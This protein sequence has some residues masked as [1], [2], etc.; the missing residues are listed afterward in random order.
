[1]KPGQAPPPLDENEEIAALIE[2]LHLTGQRLEE[3]TAGEVDGVADAEGRTF[4]LR[5]I[6]EQLRHIEA[7]KQAAI[8][9]A[10]PAHIALLD[11]QGGIVSVNEAW[12]QFASAN[13]LQGPE[14]AIGVNYLD[15]CGQ[16][17]GDAAADARLVAAGIRSVLSGEAKGFSLEYSCHSP[18][19]QRW[20]LMTATPLSDDH[21]NG[22]VVMHQDITEQKQAE[23]S[24]QGSKDLLQLVMENVPSRIFWKDRNLRYLG[25]NARFAKDAGHS[26]P[27]ELTGKTD[28]EMGWKD[29]AEL[30][31][32]D[33]RAVLE[34]GVPKLN[35]EEPQTT[36]DGNTIW[37]R[38]SKVPLRDRNNQTIGILGLYEDI[39]ERRQAEL[40]LIESERRFSDML[41]NVQLISIMLDREA[42]ITYCN[43][44]LL[45]LTGW[46]REEVIG[47]NWFDVYTPP[48]IDDLKGAFFSELLANLPDTW[49]H[50]NEI[51]TR[52]GEHRLIRWNNSVL[53]SAD[54]D[55]IG[56]ASIGEDISERKRAE[57]ALLQ[58][59]RQN[60][61]ILASVEEGIYGIDRDGGISFQNPAAAKLL[62]YG[63]DELIGRHAHATMHYARADGTPYPMAQCPIHATMID[64]VVRRVGNEVFWRKDGSS[65][66]VEYTT[67]PIHDEQNAIVGVV[68][69][70]RDITERKR[71]ELELRES[72]RMAGES[73]A[74]TAAV[75][76]IAAR[77]QAILDTVVDG[78]ITIDEDGMVET[79][80]P[81]A[82]R[83]FGYAADAVIGRN[84]KML[85]PGPYHSQHDAYL[86][87][88][89]ATG[90]AR[91]I[92]S[93]R[94]VMGRR[95]DGGS[96]PLDLSV[97]EMLLGGKRH[98]TG[99]V[100][101][102][103]E[104]KSAER[105]VLDARIEAERANAA[106]DI[107]LAN[108]SHEIRTPMNGVIGMIEVLQQSSLNGPQM[109]MANVIHDSAFAL[110]DV[111][112]DILDFSKIEAGKFEIDR[113]PMNVADVVE[114]ACE[115]L[116]SMALKKAVEL[117]LFTDPAIP[118]RVLG[119]PGR[120]RQ[121][122]INLANNA[123][124]FSSG[125]QRTGRVSVR[126]V[127][128]KINPERVLLEFQVVD[129]G[130][131]ID[132]ATLARLFTPFN[133]ADASTTRNY[134]G[135]G[136][137]LAI[138][139]QL[140]NLMDGDI[141]VQS[142]PG[143]GSLFSARIPF[144]LP[145][146]EDNADRPPHVEADSD[147]QR[148]AGLSCLVVGYP[149]GMA[150][151]LA[152]YLSYGEAIVERTQDLM[153]AQH[154]IAARPPG[155]PIVIIDTRV[156]S[157]PLEEL[158]ATA[159]AHP[160]S[161]THFVVIRRGLRRGL[162]EED[163]H[164]VSVDGNIL[165]RR[166]LLNAVAIA[167]GRATTPGQATPPDKANA[168]VASLPGETPLRRDGRILVAE[169]N[170]INR[171]VIQHQL[172]LLG[173]VADLADDGRKALARWHRG[174]YALLLTDLHMPNMDGLE[175]TAAIR[176][177]EGAGQHLP[178]VALTAN[179]LKSEAV[180]CLAAGMDDYLTKPVLLDRLQAMLEKW[181]PMPGRDTAAASQAPPASQ[182]LAV[183]D[184]TV[185]PKQIGN[186]PALI[187]RFFEDY[188]HSAQ[189]AAD[190]I[191]AA[192]ARGDWK[193]AGDGGH[194]LKS[195]SRAIGALAL[196]EVCARLEQAGKGGDAD[197][198]LA[199]EFEQ[200][201][202]AAFAAMHQADVAAP[203][204]L[205]VDD[206]AFQ[207]QLLSQQLAILGLDR[208]DA[209]TSGEQALARLEAQSAG[210]QLIFLDL[211]MPGM[212]GVEFIRRL[213]AR[214]YTGALI[215]VSG[216]DARI[217]ETA[218]RLA[219]AHRLN[220]LGHMNKPVQPERLEALLERWR[221][222]APK[223][224]GKASK[225][226]GAEAVRR[227][228][229][230]GELVNHY[231][232]KVDVA[233]GAFT[234]VETLV[235]WQHPD[236]GLVFPDEFIGVAEEN[237][238]IDDLTGVVLTEALGQ[239]RRWR[240]QGLN[241][242][243]AV[244]V[245]MHNLARL[246]FAD[247]VL[248]EIVRSGVA[249]EDLILEVTESR[250]MKD[251]L[252]PLDIL[253]RLRLKHIGLSIDDFGTGHS[254]LSQLRDIP[255]DEL[256]IDRSF[257]H[258]ADRDKTRC[259]IFSASLGMARQLGMKTV[260]EGVED[261]ADW[262]FLRQQGCDLAQGYFI[263]RPMPAGDL[264]AW[265]A[266]WRARQPELIS[267]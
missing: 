159:R 20:F 106:K 259:A 146:V 100:R 179:A 147:R 78:I 206:E 196:G 69:A 2:T 66:Q 207:L 92:G 82:E 232:P 117:T 46:Q 168:T 260:A 230:G 120:L 11:T 239:T 114:K 22:V 184:R 242:R 31:R 231:Q 127:L 138:S 202:A 244:N 55:V 225:R 246:E 74:D 195:S 241:L 212:D 50:E 142:E 224:A 58:L 86:A 203:N 87:H 219:R 164:L 236:D 75:R 151:D 182:R 80:N 47:R 123:I 124:K 201:L 163:S 192:I 194:K 261:R 110:L 162:R 53:R 174:N 70:F 25:C 32:G 39:T 132:A 256:K 262:N 187:A 15:I 118:A 79:L 28:F 126:V 67:A 197:A 128:A 26:R 253:T 181:L 171:S 105:A 177:A 205:L 38:T 172:S 62:G 33:D 213:V 143:K 186:D 40:A 153:V 160:E 267:T 240:D 94:E 48:E 89:R 56:T 208:I 6:Q 65:V 148:V 191:R 264:S 17:R 76:D 157:P 109:E 3:L 227:A 250:L 36:P 190:E 135:T 13:A 215:L 37:L 103:T 54:G 12:R 189:T 170:E 16:A 102:I 77:L 14:Y 233:S 52:S 193:T 156:A 204:I 140:A 167:A 180:R 5:H 144:A 81:A 222:T 158:R 145:V 8:L 91:I 83:I 51:L 10:L 198:M 116:D 24:L 238:L 136:L 137:G 263:A 43:D 119:D 185:L 173:Y 113:I 221:S 226:Y 216:E 64:G 90:A 249:A 95:K 131:G 175:L 178:I 209:C 49:H 211:N 104:R 235:R 68:V 73:K 60:E 210:E 200:A 1:M 220:V 96:F 217:L 152:A 150:S 99:V 71:V 248:S 251:V 183:L 108:M 129:N 85:M 229:V 139:R 45:N 44:Y 59:Q 41:A 141:G 134:G 21:P 107:F 29:Q 223:A 237:G 165:T 57:Q 98:Y 84:I 122:L 35:I 23:K 27:D 234:G 63:I 115:I 125:K 97:S 130:I 199:L 93:G 111:I 252:A 34:S 161:D 176:R 255:F 243:V 188:R 169:D 247:F 88:Y 166:T 7:A 266:D 133:Q 218:V 121:I 214:A 155:R 72:E 30:Y 257:V 18:T 154:W 265:L 9:N 228:I 42:R 19:Q 254:S 149:D 61:L 258:G 245:S 4:L 101:N 112:N